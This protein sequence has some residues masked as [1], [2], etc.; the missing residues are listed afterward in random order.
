M[1]DKVLNFFALSIMF[2]ITIILSPFWL[3]LWAWDRCDDIA[4]EREREKREKEYDNNMKSILSEL[5][6]LKEEE[7]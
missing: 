1:I 3:I 4:I 2:A 5:Q 6:G 7:K